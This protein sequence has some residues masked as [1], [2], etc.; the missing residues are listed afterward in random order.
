MTKS[1]IKYAINIDAGMALHRLYYYFV[2]G[3]VFHVKMKYVKTIQTLKALVIE[4]ME[5]WQ[6]IK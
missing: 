6:I 2:G 4:L 1:Q 3:I 5:G